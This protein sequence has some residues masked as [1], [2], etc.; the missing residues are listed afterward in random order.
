[1]GRNARGWAGRLASLPRPLCFF[2]RIAPSAEKRGPNDTQPKMHP[3][4]GKASHLI[5]TRGIANVA[6]PESPSISL[7]QDQWRSP[8]FEFLSVAMRA[9]H[10]RPRLGG[11][12][13]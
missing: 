9:T 3:A 8:V 6:T 11:L 13:G 10:Y 1:M 12:L 5:S 7:P 2:R 4:S